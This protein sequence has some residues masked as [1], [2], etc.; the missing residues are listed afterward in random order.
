MVARNLIWT[1]AGTADI[2]LAGNYND[3]T[4]SLN[5]AASGPNSA[6]TLNFGPG[7]GTLTGTASALFAYFDGVWTLS[8]VNLT[9][10]QDLYTGSTNNTTLTLQNASTVDVT[11]VGTARVDPVAVGAG[12][13][14]SLVVNGANTKYIS[15]YLYDGYAGSGFVTVEAGGAINITSDSNGLTPVI[16]GYTAHASGVLDVL[17]GG[18][19]AFT[20]PP[21]SNVGVDVGYSGGASGTVD[22]AGAGSLFN[23]NTNALTVGDT[24]NGFFTVEAGATVEVGTTSSA[25]TVPLLVGYHGGSNGSV[26][27]TGAGSTF[28]STGVTSIGRGG[29]GLLTITNGGTFDNITDAIGDGAFIVGS[30]GSITNGGTGTVEVSGNGLLQTGQNMLVGY[31]ASNGT[32]FTDTGGQ[33]VVANRLEIGV[34]DVINGVTFNATGNVNVGAGGTISIGGNL[35][36]ASG[37]SAL[38]VGTAVGSNGTLNVSGAGAFVTTNGHYANIGNVGTGVVNVTQGGSILVG[39]QFAADAA[40][41]IGNSGGTGNLV[42]SD[43]GSTYTAVGGINIGNSGT[44]SLLVEN[45]GTVNSGGNTANDINEGITLGRNAG[46]SG[47]LTVTGVG[48][49]LTNLGRFAVGGT[50]YYQNSPGGP[51]NVSILA[52]GV[53][54]TSLPAAYTNGASSTNLNGFVPAAAAEIGASGGGSGSSVTVGGTGSQWNITG[55]LYVGDGSSGSLTVNTGG[56]VA[57]SNADFGTLAGATATVTVDGAGSALAITGGL[58]VGDSGVGGLSI[59]N[60]ATVT[61]VEGAIGFSTG[62]SGT[63]D[64]EG[65]GSK[66][67]ITDSITVGGAG[68]AV[69][70]VGQG[71]TL[72]VANNLSIAAGAVSTI[73]GVLDPVTGTINGTQNIGAG[74]AVNYGTLS[75]GATGLI[76]AVGQGAMLNVGTIVSTGSTGGTIEIGSGASLTLN[77]YQGSTGPVFSGAATPSVVFADGTGSLTLTDLR[78]FSSVLINGFVAGD[79]IKIGAFDHLLYISTANTIAEYLYVYGDSAQTNLEGIL[80]FAAGT[81]A[82]AIVAG[83]Q[84]SCFAWG[85]RIRR[86]DGDVAVQALEVGDWV[87]TRDGTAAP[88]TWIG[89]RRMRHM[90]R[91]PRP[92]TVQPIRIEADAI[93][94]GVPCRD[95]VLSPDHALYLGGH[96]I[97]AKVLINEASIAQLDVDE[98]TYYHIE[99]ADHAVVLAENAPAESYLDTGDRHGFADGPT[100]TLHPEFGQ[101]RREA[102]G[103]APFAVDGAVVE[104]QRAAILA[105]AAIATTDDPDLRLDET[106][107]GIV[108]RS[109]TA[110]PG[111]ISADPRD[112]RVL[113]VKIAALHAGARRIALD[114]LR[115]VEGWQIVEPEG[116]W[117][118][119]AALV[120]RALLEA[121]ETLRVTLAATLPYR[122]AA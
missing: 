6:D 93:A 108:I 1:A 35:I 80:S 15:A 62:G 22:V 27:V 66:L 90:R 121:G 77:G 122:R 100:V 88:I 28:M 14:A 45:G 73:T 20:A 98:I 44:G 8:G 72:S 38:L 112:R 118:N 65:S 9:L 19:F 114:D 116:R 42:V 11:Y 43:K 21:S 12:L 10:G 25:V 87:V 48:S 51:G 75:L 104:Q 54:N 47:T 106:A 69:L 53:I 52:G 57:A 61:A 3:T 99:L 26:L 82:Q 68:Q 34:V 46:G 89:S 31:N 7:G 110:I 76:E 84:V 18:T 86:L 103:C 70:T 107:D 41:V 83:V 113:G 94:D 58:T 5:P 67:A 2:G 78:D 111:H 97:P 30:G 95:L 32:L 117:T 115:L 23:L 39:V 85:T 60:G 13:S 17:N 120:P 59:T 56:K 71:A 119:G 81:S 37:T 64:V 79:T 33:V 92:E 102:E 16:V 50:S 36:T 105:R 101:A 29:N 4:D 74:G 49:V 40:T 24:G 63:V 109:R 55:A 91:H 96:L